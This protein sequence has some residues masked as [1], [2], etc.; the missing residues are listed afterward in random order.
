MHRRPLNHLLSELPSGMLHLIVSTTNNPH[1]NDL[2]IN[3]NGVVAMSAPGNV[4]T[5]LALPLHLQVIRI[6]SSQL[7]LELAHRQIP[8]T[9]SWVPHYI[10]PSHTFMAPLVKILDQ[11]LKAWRKAHLV[12][13][14]SGILSV[15]C[16]PIF[17]HTLCEKRIHP[18][19]N[20]QA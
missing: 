12:P 18:Q 4:P 8:M 15:G 11:S 1:L 9:Q 14:M 16:T 7:F 17:D 10:R 20:D 19:R 13:Q 2:V 3:A 6:F 5:L